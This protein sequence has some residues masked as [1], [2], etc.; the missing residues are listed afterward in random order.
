MKK[1][2]WMLTAVLC[3]LP[4]VSAAEE[5]AAQLDANLEQAVSA[6]IEQATGKEGLVGRQLQ[7]IAD[8][9][10]TEIFSGIRIVPQQVVAFLYS[11]TMVGFEDSAYYQFKWERSERLQQL[12]VEP[13]ASDEEIARLSEYVPQDSPEVK[14]YAAQMRHAIDYAFTQVFPKKYVE[15]LFD[16]GMGPSNY[17][18]AHYVA[19]KSKHTFHKDV[20]REIESLH[21]DLAFN[22]GCDNQ[23][24]RA[25]WDWLL[26][27]DIP[28]LQSAE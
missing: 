7:R 12:L 6:S 4:G 11:R 18:P 9:M 24:F 13:N 26:A 5:W 25:A 3:V 22:V 23:T 10:S 17:N 27:E 19:I 2:I 15:G 28:P 21:S 20:Q 1:L 14:E 16:Y 8:R